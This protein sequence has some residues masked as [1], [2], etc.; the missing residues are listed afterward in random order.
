[1]SKTPHSKQCS[2][3]GEVKPLS[4]FYRRKD[5]PDGRRSY[6]KVCGR[7]SARRWHAANP[8]KAKVNT[9]RWFAANPEKARAIAKSYRDA[10]P[11]KIKADNKRWYAAN[12]ERAKEQRRR[13]QAAN[14]E[15][16][17]ENGRRWRDANREKVRDARRRRRALE[18]NAS[19]GGFTDAQFAQLCTMSGGRCL[20]CGEVKP[21]AADHIVAL[22][23]GG[24]DA[25]LLH[26]EAR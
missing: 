20:A 15:K 8:E 16:T 13:Y 3:C 25:G 21:L 1:M 9:K 12:L 22:A 2:K 11:E 17:R 6:C 18:A 5:R 23:N 14:P 7:E 24:R 26:H 10:N 4:E 19:G